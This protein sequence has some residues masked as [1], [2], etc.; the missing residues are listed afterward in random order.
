MP[1]QMAEALR[2]AADGT[3][4]CMNI[5]APVAQRIVLKPSGGSWNMTT[6]WGEFV[7]AAQVQLGD[8]LSFTQNKAGDFRIHITKGVSQKGLDKAKDERQK[9]LNKAKDER[10]RTVATTKSTDAW[11]AAGQK[12][13]EH[14]QSKGGRSNVRGAADSRTTA[15]GQKRRKIDSQD[16]ATHILDVDA[17]ENNGEK[18]LWWD[19]LGDSDDETD[20]GQKWRSLQHRGVM[21]PAP[22]KQHG[23]KILYGEPGKRKEPITLTPEAEEVATMYAKM[24]GTDYA[25]KAVFRKNFFHG[26]LQVLS[27]VSFITH[28]AYSCA[29]EF[30]QLQ[31]AF[32]LRD[33]RRH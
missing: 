1:K 8:R 18:R 14:A 12:I 23:I 28:R 16:G 11:R 10:R 4:R 27:R 13:G 33:K 5:V 19:E 29:T 25:K 24:L 21:F 3:S 15:R 32:L 6:G 30:H 17:Y 20:G 7:R 31:R 26:F 22:Y 9:G 2:A